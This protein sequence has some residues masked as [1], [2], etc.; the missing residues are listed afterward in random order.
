M[1]E[2]RKKCTCGRSK[3]GFCD[4]T[5]KEIEVAVKPRK[6][7]TCGRSKTGFCDDAHKEIQVAAKPRKVCTCG[8]SKTGYC[9]NSHEHIVDTN[10]V[11]ID[12]NTKE[13]EGDFGF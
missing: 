9:D 5:H 1:N 13:E 4:D 6:V 3:T 12:P 11:K 7:C 8:R 2:D 10:K